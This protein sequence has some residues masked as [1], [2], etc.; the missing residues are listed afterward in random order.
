MF[1]V[2]S[3]NVGA[4]DSGEVSELL[5]E[6]SLLVKEDVVSEET[7]ERTSDA[8]SPTLAGLD[9]SFSGPSRS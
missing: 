7:E 3:I 4:D 6:G 8:G 9:S 1:A 5:L 2:V